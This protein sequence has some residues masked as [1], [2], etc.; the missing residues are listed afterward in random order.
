MKGMTRVVLIDPR[1]ESR[2]ALQRMLGGVNSIWLAEVCTSYSTAAQSVGEIV[3]DLTIISIDSNPMEALSV[4]QTITKITPGAVILPTSYSIDPELLLQLMELGVRRILNMPV[5]IDRLMQTIAQLAPHSSQNDD[6]TPKLV[7]ITGASGGIGCTSLAVN[8]GVCLAR[9]NPSQ[10]VV[11]V[12]FDLLFGT[13]DSGLDII[14]EHTLMELV[15]D[16]DR[17]DLPL[18]KRSLIRHESGLLV[19]PHPVSMEE[20]SRIDPEDLK[21]L[22]GMLKV[23]FDTVIIDC[24]KSLQASDFIA[25]D[26]ADL[27]LLVV[28]L[29]LNCLRNSARLLQLFRQD[30]YNMGDKIRV[31]VNRAGSHAQEIGGRRAEEVLGTP[32]SWQIPNDTRTFTAAMSR[33]VP[34]DQI[35]KGSQTHRV[36]MDIARTLQKGG[37]ES[38]SG[39]GAGGRR[40]RLPSLF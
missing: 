20:S 12:D 31:V 15:R 24:S 40:P 13:V 16:L 21:R 25:F 14:P 10:S 1:E 9:A 18:L 22:V 11:L 37:A 32:L 30:E 29:D 19:L 35:A 8:L 6:G 34:I 7:A 26:A 17:I 38:G 36:F 3:P 28:Q 5:E 2:K 39:A 4:I 33:G 23:A 27:I